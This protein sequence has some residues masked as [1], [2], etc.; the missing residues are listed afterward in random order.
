MNSLTT[1]AKTDYNF[2][3]TKF[4][5]KNLHWTNACRWYNG[6]HRRQQYRV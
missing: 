6:C 1:H 4:Y 5:F 2:Q 3:K